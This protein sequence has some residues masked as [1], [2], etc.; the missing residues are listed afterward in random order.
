MARPTDRQIN[1]IGE[2][3]NPE[4]IVTVILELEYDEVYIHKLKFKYAYN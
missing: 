3:I 4:L 2:I 1:G